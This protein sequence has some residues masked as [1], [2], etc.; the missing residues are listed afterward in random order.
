MLEGYQ[1]KVLYQGARHF[2]YIFC[3]CVRK[4]E[5]T[6]DIFRD[7][8]CQVNHD[9]S[10]VLGNTVRGRA[11]YKNHYLILQL[12]RDLSNVAEWKKA[13]VCP[14]RALSTFLQRPSARESCL[15]SSLYPHSL[16]YRELV[17]RANVQGCV[18]RFGI[19]LP[20]RLAEDLDNSR[21]MRDV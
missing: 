4:E 16:G 5:C 11:G 15:G 17:D 1:K 18:S 10:K 7:S 9:T 21:H 12:Q 3:D 8:S 14:L 6:K 19:H 13:S 2:I 20:L